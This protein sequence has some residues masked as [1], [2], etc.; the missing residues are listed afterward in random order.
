MKYLVDGE[1]LT[2][3]EVKNRFGNWDNQLSRRQQSVFDMVK[4]VVCELERQVF[5]YADI[6]CYF[7]YFT[8]KVAESFPHFQC[9][10]IDY[11]TDNIRIAHLLNE[12][13]VKYLE[14]SVY[15]LDFPDEYFDLITFQEVIEHIDRP[16][17]AVREMNRVLKIGGYLIVSTPNA[18]AFA[19]IIY[20]IFREYR[21]SFLRYTN[22]SVPVPHEIFFENVEWNRHIYAWSASTL[23]TLLLCNGFEYVEHRI[24]ANTLWLRLFPGIASELV[25]LVKRVAGAG[26]KII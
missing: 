25:F 8:R 26:K 16:V 7:G 10:G 5:K 18:V 22:R 20:N 11:F 19:N 24:V 6:G 14:M 21:N 3:Q 12:S 2:E 9:Y 1:D 13:G 4:K 23:S 15:D 17:D